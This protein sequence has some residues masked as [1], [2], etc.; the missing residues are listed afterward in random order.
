M[1]AVTLAHPSATRM[2][3]WPWSLVMAL[4]WL[5]P[6]A[7]F[8]ATI[9]TEKSWRLPSPLTTAGLGLLS[10]SVVASAWMSPFSA[11]S[12]ARTWPT[13]G[14]CAFLF[15][16]HHELTAP[17]ESSGQRVDAIARFLA[18]AGAIF[19][20]LSFLGWLRLATKYT[21]GTRNDFPFGHS[22]YVAGC[23][24][25][26][27]PWLA[28]S[29]VRSRGAGRFAAAMAAAV[30]VAALL[31][32]S[33]RGGVIAVI[34]MLGLGLA[35]VLISSSLSRAKKTG[36]IVAAIAAG[37]IAVAANPRLREVALGRSWSDAA[38]ESNQQRSAMLE[39]GWRLGAE[40]PALGWGP[41][42]VPLA[43]PR[44]RAALDGGVENA[45]QLH[46]TPMQIWATLGATGFL[47][48][49]LIAAGV[50]RS[51]ICGYRHSSPSPVGRAAGFS[52][53]G[54]A[55]FSLTD[56]QFDLP[57]IAALAAAASAVFGATIGEIREQPLDAKWRGV[58]LAAGLALLA[59][60][61]AGIGRDLLAR[62]AYD[63]GLAARE[64][65]D[66]AGFITKQERATAFSP[67]DP[68]FRHQ[69]AGSIIEHRR[70]NRDPAMREQLARKAAQ[71]LEASLVTRAHEE[72]AHFNLG[73]LR[74]ELG[75]PAAAARHFTAAARLVPSKG[76]VY[77]G[78]GLALLE[79]Q[80]SADAVR[81]FALEWIN[82]PR[83]LTSP[84][85]ETSAL[86]TLRPAVRAEMNRLYASLRREHPAA[87]MGDAWTRWWLGEKISSAEL[88]RGF[89]RESADFIAT[90][91]SHVDPV[92]TEPGAT[93]HPWTRLYRAWRSR[94]FSEVARSDA[95]LAAALGRRAARHPMDFQNFLTADTEGEAALL[96]TL[97]RER[98]GYGVLAL[99]PD[100][101]VLSDAYFVQENVV[102]SDW[103]AGLFPPKGWLP[104]RFLLALLPPDAR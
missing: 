36:L 26:F 53:A 104:G 19:A 102:A 18:F 73:W 30:A 83:Q 51:A 76:G 57:V 7:G 38:R 1:A 89:T 33:S 15:W 84:S 49:G 99:H 90:Q 48:L 14:A 43:Y 60:P 45:L 71:V 96:R 41:G 31:A 74:L 37:A 65:G 103:A 25:L 16:L 4:L 80:R 61:V 3:T 86:A 58:I 6:V 44:V 95:A 97:H 46:N 100:G 42:T 5:L 11:L 55:I 47:A 69:I 34:G 62:R 93:V 39:A 9:L 82:D 66:F 101:P 40:R 70:S 68:F 79:Q 52:L 75:E 56:H 23:L 85:W 67:G 91:A 12:L 2:F 21:W 28:L 81:A 10:L 24:V 94:S 78:L 87:A 22:N 92:P 88:G 77:L 63:Q 8:A 98:T 72:F 17:G 29:L 50:T 13:L 64:A 32:T 59:G 20:V 54:Y 27:L 35:D